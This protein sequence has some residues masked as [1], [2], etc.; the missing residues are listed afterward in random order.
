MTSPA[1]QTPESALPDA[2]RIMVLE[3]DELLRERVLAPRLRQF[4]FEVAALGCMADMQ[5]SIRSYRPDIVLLDI[6]LPDTDGFHV[7][8]WLRETV[9]NIGIVMLTGRS[10]STDRV[11]GLTE[12]ADTYLCKPIEIDVLV[13][14][15]HSLARRLKLRPDVAVTVGAWRLESDDWILLSPH[16]GRIALSKTERCL[17]GRF[18]QEP[19]HV[20]S[21]DALINALTDNAFDFDPHRLDSLIHRLRRK[22]LKSLRETLPLEAV[23]GHGYLLSVGNW[24]P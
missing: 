14:T 12:G 13:A 2:L 15:L 21:R 17:L 9:P 11:R 5:A 20:I 23:Y 7:A 10:D 22:V 6:G 3:D 18:I 24:P 16:G 8:K 19:N 1:H 4:G